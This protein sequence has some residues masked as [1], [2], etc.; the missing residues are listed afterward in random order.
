MDKIKIVILDDQQL[1]VDGLKTILQLNNQFEVVGTAFN[2][3]VGFELVERL[4]PDIVLMD[5]RM[6]VMDGVECTRRIKL[7]FP[8]IFVIILTTFD[9]DADL[10]KALQYGA[11]GYILKDIEGHQLYHIIQDAM[12]G[13]VIL[14]GKLASKLSKHLNPSKV[15]VQ[16]DPHPFSNRELEITRLICDGL[17][18]REI[19]KQLFLTEGTVKNYISKIYE[20]IGIHDRA[21]AIVYFRSL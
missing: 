10:M 3:E 1:M 16:G 7:N 19:A 17:T 21:K 6:P 4:Q 14:P 8:H 20:M 13:N 15:A 9:D 18:N 11:S 12:A 2:G 5:V